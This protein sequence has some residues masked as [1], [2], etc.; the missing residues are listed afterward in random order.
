M[1]FSSRSLPE[2]RISSTDI[3]AGPAIAHHAPAE[4][5]TR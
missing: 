5:A 2:T 1:R 4:S 3:T